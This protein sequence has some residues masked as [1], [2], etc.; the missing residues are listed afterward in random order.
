MIHL[1]SIGL[2]IT[3]PQDVVA[4]QS[5]G[6]PDDTQSFGDPDDIHYKLEVYCKKT[7]TVT[8][9]GNQREIQ[10]AIAELDELFASDGPFTL[11]EGD[12]G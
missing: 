11:M 12:D 3:D 10:A 5:F 6:D 4:Y 1:Q 8:A 9:H 2:R 7:G